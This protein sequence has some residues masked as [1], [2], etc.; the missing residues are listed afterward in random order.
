MFNNKLKNNLK[1]YDLKYTTINIEKEI[2]NFINDK[3]SCN[4]LMN[5]FLQ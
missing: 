3:T 5:K 2:Q 1:K 4:N